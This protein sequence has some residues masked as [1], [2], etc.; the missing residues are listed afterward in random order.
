[1]QFDLPTIREQFPS[2]VRPA[3]F[4]DNPGGTQI[5][6][7]SLDRIVNYLTFHNANHGGAFPTS[8][9]SD[10]VLDE[11]HSAMAEFLNAA[12][13]D[14]V[15]FGNNMTTLT[16]HMSRSIARQW[17]K[18]DKIVVTRLDHDANISPWVLVAQERGVDVIHVDFNPE[19]GTLNMQEMER[20][21]AEKP[22]FV[23][24]GYASNALGTI[25]PVKKIIEMA[26]AVGAQVYIDAVQYAAH[27]P[28]DVQDL[29]CDFLV[30]SSY[31]F[32]G[33]HAGILFGRHELLEE[34]FAYK[35]RVVPDEL[36]GKFMTGTQNHEGI[37]GVLGAVEYFDWLGRT[38]GEDQRQK[39][40]VR[41]QGRRL[42]LKQALGAVRAYEY[43]IS[44]SLLDTLMEMPGVTL[45]G[46]KDVQRLEERVPTFSFRLKGWH[47][48]QLAEEFSRQGVYV[49][50][51]NYYAI[52]VTERLGIEES[53][54]MLRVGPVHYNT[55]EE[56]ERFR[57]VL[58]KIVL[59]GM[60]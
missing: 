58:G 38:F 5:A 33:P 47:P 40:S 6:R 4:L 29:G 54:G 41:F 42:H 37:A 36:P 15:I 14:E 3:I 59:S 7:K 44:R 53:G 57:E 11:A 60:R 50:D 45:Y 56:I 30:C 22:R 20:A 27:G 12:S 46:L 35:L 16:L 49:W 19:D 55:L 10:A 8:Y 25:N 32:F 51:G 28:I 31:K 21:L 39:Y 23:A 52:S 1:M 43:E 13:K 26:H 17:E 24:V 34:L 48:R 18:G 2:L 9:D